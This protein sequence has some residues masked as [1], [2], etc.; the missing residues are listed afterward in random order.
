MLD[1]FATIKGIH[2]ASGLFLKGDLLYVIGDNS[3]LLYEYNIRD[4]QLNKFP[5][6]GNFPKSEN[7]PKTDKPDFEA[8]FAHENSLY[9]LGSGSTPQ[10]NQM[11][12]YRL[13][14]R[15][16]IAHDL[17]QLYTAM[18]SAHAIADEDLNIEGAIYT[19]SQWYLFNR[20]NGSSAKNGIFIIK[21]ADLPTAKNADFI[22]IS[23]PKE[24]KVR[25]SFTDAVL[26]Q[27]Q[28]YFLAAA[29]DTTSTYNDGK[30]VGSYI[31]GIDLATLKLKTFKKI[32]EDKKFE[33]LTFLDKKGSQLEFLICEDSDSESSSTVIYKVLV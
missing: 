9:V 20:G 1:V 16:V 27:N 28:I 15:L 4:K 23:L 24:N 19:G 25:A 7:I 21:G 11:I 2:A 26:Y 22:A 14:T 17:S 29:E 8:V 13:D 33:G 3:S 6:L 10:R 30:I 31:G 32:A 18:K 5:L 12:E